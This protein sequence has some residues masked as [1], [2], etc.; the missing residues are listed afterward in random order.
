[1]KKDKTK[2][3]PEK[4]AE[5]YAE[6]EKKKNEPSI[7]PPELSNKGPEPVPKPYLCPHCGKPLSSRKEPCPHCGYHGYIPLSEGETRRIRWV[8]FAV[9]LVLALLVYFL[10]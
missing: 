10:F 9:L 8:L 7:S 4:L 5:F 3:D 6:T 1:M 2:I